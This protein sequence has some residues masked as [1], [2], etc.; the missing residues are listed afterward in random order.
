MKPAAV[1]RAKRVETPGVSWSAAE[2][3]KYVVLA[4]G[5]ELL[6]LDPSTLEVVRRIATETGGAQIRRLEFAGRD[7]RILGVGYFTGICALVDVAT[8]QLIQ[9]LEGADTEIKSVA[10]S[11][12]GRVAFSTREG[13]VWIWSPNEAGEWELEEIM[14]YSETDVKTVLWDGEFLIALGY[15]GESVVYHRWED[16]I[17]TKWEIY[18][19]LREDSTVWD[20][21]VI[22]TP[23]GDFLGLVTQNGYFHLYQ[24]EKY[25]A[26]IVSLP[27]STHPLLA[28]CQ[29]TVNGTPGFAFIA[30]RQ[31]LT[32]IDPAGQPLLTQPVLAAD[33]EP[34]DLIFAPADNAFLVVST[35]F[36][37]RTRRSAL[38]KL[39]IRQGWSG[40]GAISEQ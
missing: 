36:K 14:E 4:S 20:G 21:A 35:Q 39:P 25:W 13:S 40:G 3:G 9:R 29:G 38:T 6:V 34:L 16:E 18:Q 37:Q 17:C 19:I 8:G 10:F 23:T 15:D 12:Q 32:V 28:V 24:K 1:E 27:V 7:S 31:V 22:S 26:K 2:N 11:A 5:S 30:D 33:E